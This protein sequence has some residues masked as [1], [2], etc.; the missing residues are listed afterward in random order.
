MSISTIAYAGRIPWSGHGTSVNQAMTSEEAIQLA[1]LDWDVGLF[2]IHASG[3]IDI[4]EETKIKVDPINIPKSY[5]VL[6]LDTMQPLGVVGKVFHPLQNRQAFEFFDEIVGSRKAI[7]ET[8]GSL[9]DGRKVWILAR[10]QGNI[11]IR[12]TDDEINKYMLLANGHDGTMR[13][14]AKFTPIRVVC[15][16]TLLAALAGEGREISLKHSSTILTR[17]NDV[18]EALGIINNYYENFEE[19]A[20]YLATRQLTETA[21]NDLLD[22]IGLK[23]PT[24]GRKP[25]E[26]NP[27]NS[28]LYLFENGLGSNLSSSRGTAWGLF[29]AVAEFTD[30][31]RSTRITNP[32][33]TE[34]EARLFSQWFGSGEQLKL[35]AWNVIS[36]YA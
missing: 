1:G 24:E 23:E 35:T 9:L 28:I 36:K 30:H 12:G 22:R 8:A 3:T 33:V 34:S 14:V 4:D 16:N 26:T 7:Y 11:G 25:R 31:V 21:V 10:V 19:Q 32:S 27:R 2:P 20:N 18:R 29:N 15:Y 5:A 17:I 13:V 6:R